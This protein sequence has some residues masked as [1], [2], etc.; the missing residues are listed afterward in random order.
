[1]YHFTETE[2]EAGAE[3]AAVIMQKDKTRILPHPYKQNAELACKMANICCKGS[4][5]NR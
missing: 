3:A 2:A 4:I 1:M 5:W